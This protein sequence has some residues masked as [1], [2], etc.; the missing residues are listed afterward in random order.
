MN[1]GKIALVLACQYYRADVVIFLLSQSNTD[2][3]DKGN[4]SLLDLM[5]EERVNCLDFADD[6]EDNNR[7]RQIWVML[8]K[9]G[10]RP[11]N[12]KVLKSGWKLEAPLLC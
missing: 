2:V 1:N 4:G 10:V 3:G 6:E 12:K 7:Y 8:V 5:Y 11:T 9:R